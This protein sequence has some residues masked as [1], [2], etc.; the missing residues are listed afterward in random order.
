[1]TGIQQQPRCFGPDGFVIQI[2][3]W[4]FAQKFGSPECDKGHPHFEK[5]FDAIILRTGMGDDNAIH[6]PLLDKI[7][8]RCQ[9][10]ISL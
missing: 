9:R 6:R 5:I 8:Y 4:M 7:A 3:T 10:V 1:M 2:D